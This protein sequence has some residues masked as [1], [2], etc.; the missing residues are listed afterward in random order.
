MD[1]NTMNDGIIQEVIKKYL[2]QFS[3]ENYQSNYPDVS[4]DYHCNVLE[5]IE[6]ELIKKIKALWLNEYQQ[7]YRTSKISE[8]IIED[9]IGDNQE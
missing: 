9:L 4:I 5:E 6:E 8:L 1:A 7:D 2:N 3:P